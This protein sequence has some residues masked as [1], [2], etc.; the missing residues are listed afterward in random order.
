MNRHFG[1]FV[2]LMLFPVSVF[3]QAPALAGD[4]TMIEVEDGMGDEVEASTSPITAEREGLAEA[5]EGNAA[6]ETE[7]AN[8]EETEAL[9][10]ADDALKEAEGEANEDTERHDYTAPGVAMELHGYMRFRGEMMDNFFLGRV[11]PNE[12]PLNRA[13]DL[14]FG[15]Y[16]PLEDDKPAC[17]PSGDQPCDQHNLHSATMRLRLEPS[18]HVSDHVRLH[19][20]IDIFDN[21]VLGSTPDSYA[22][23]P[24]GSGYTQ[25]ATI[26]RNDMTT[27]LVP[28]TAGRNGVMDSIVVRRAWGEVRNS[29]LGELRFGRMGNHWGMGM[30]ANGGTGIDQDYQSDVDRVMAAIKISGFYL[31]GAWDFASEGF[32]YQ[33]TA[34]LGG[35]P[36]DRSRLD[37]VDQFVFTLGRQLSNEEKEEQLQLGNAVI[38]GGLYFQY[39]SQQL[40]YTLAT[41]DSSVSNLD[42]PNPG[43]VRRGAE[44][45]TPD[46]WVQFFFQDLRIELE[47]ALVLG[48]IENQG[49]TYDP[50]NKVSLA[51]FGYA[52]EMDYRLLD[53]KALGIHFA[54]GLGTGDRDTEGLS[55]LSSLGGQAGAGRDTTSSAFYFHPGYRVDLILWR[56][57]MRQIGSAY[58]L[59]PGIS[60]DFIRSKF[61]QNLGG[62]FDFIYSGAMESLQTSGNS[63]DLGVE[64]DFSVYYRSEDGPEIWDG[65]YSMIQAGFFFPMQGLGYLPGEFTPLANPNLGNATMLRLVLGI[66]F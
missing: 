59:K 13:A 20:Q 48:T 45:F 32:V 22:I 3:A 9:P 37:D 56:T 62:R 54:T 35:I 15:L 10:D 1:L 49:T 18:I 43:F 31:T 12:D 63:N 33:D 17:G 11:P 40:D 25:V 41:G 29:A 14:P 60:Y 51:Q 64:L 8:A 52:L 21:L 19:L 36:F 50:N 58:Y 42:Q 44:V 2:F 16:R 38:N 30:V 55:R 39:R 6:V 28:P 4:E 23:R 46:L 27:T 34:D 24:D 7:E 66:Q 65:F 26:N 47:A 61:G 5:S 53:D 57:I